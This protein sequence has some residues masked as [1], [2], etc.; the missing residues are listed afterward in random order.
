MKIL[1]YKQFESYLESGRHLLYHTLRED[2]HLE[3][4]LNRDLMSP[5][6]IARGPKGVCFS[7]SINWTNDADNKYRLVLDSDLLKRHGYNSIP[8]QEFTYASRSTER[9][10]PSQNVWKGK[11]DWYKDSKRSTPHN[12]SSLPPHNKSIMETEFEERVLK[13]IK[14]VG[15]FIIYMDFIEYPKDDIL[16]LVK[17]YLEKY[18]YI[19]TRIMDKVNSSKV[20]EFDIET[21]NNKKTSLVP[22]IY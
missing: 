22:F 5:G 20:K 14:N 10:I 3:Y 8:L 15:R 2:L 12:I 11:L 4:V 19:K 21:L 9:K 7:R 16:K 17:N 6:V 18:P 1:R 13:E